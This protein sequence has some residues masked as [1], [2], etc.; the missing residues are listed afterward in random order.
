MSH[1]LANFMDFVHRLFLKV[2]KEINNPFE[3]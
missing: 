2:L 3:A 1:G